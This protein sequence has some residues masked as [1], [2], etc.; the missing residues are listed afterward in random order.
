MTLVKSL[1][2]QITDSTILNTT[3]TS[4][5]STKRA[6]QFKK[7]SDAAKDLATDDGLNMHTHLVKAEC[8]KSLCRTKKCVELCG[9]VTSLKT[10]G[11]LTHKPV[12]GKY[13]KYISDNDANGKNE[14]QYYIKNNDKNKK[15]DVAKIASY[16]QN[17]IK[18]K[19]KFDKFITNNEDKFPE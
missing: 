9:K 7:K 3:L 4:S 2:T 10:V 8:D 17:D 5:Y 19:P 14:T 6:V 18:D 12:A 13:A 1:I 16:K 15:V 11:F